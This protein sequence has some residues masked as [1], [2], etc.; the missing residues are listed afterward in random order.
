M[1]KSLQS[2]TMLAWESMLASIMCLAA[3]TP[4]STLMASEMLL[5]VRAWKQLW[6][7]LSMVPSGLRFWMTMALAPGPPDEGRAPP[8]TK[9]VVAS[10]F[11]GLFDF[12]MGL[13]RTASPSR[14]MS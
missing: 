7:T 4:A 14:V 12:V 1:G 11:I 2:L 8:S 3:R 10:G 9:M 13:L 5:V 6:A